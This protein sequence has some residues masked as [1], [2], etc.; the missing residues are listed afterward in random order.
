[1]FFFQTKNFSI[2]IHAANIDGGVVR[3]V[4]PQGRCKV[5]SIAKHKTVN[6]FAAKYL[7]PF[8]ADQQSHKYSE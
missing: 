6:E 4:D 2:C 5:D 1:M 7:S 8:L 3:Y